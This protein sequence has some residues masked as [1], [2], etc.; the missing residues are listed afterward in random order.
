M[1]DT[2]KDVLR[3]DEPYTIRQDG[4]KLYRYES[5]NGMYIIQHPTGGKYTD[6]T[7]VESATY[8]Y[9]ETDE[10]IG[11]ETDPDTIIR[12]KSEAFDYLTGSDNNE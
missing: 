1:A 8:T 11:G 2:G 4:V 10:P 6:A 5:D 7:D 12:Q 9:T 3:P